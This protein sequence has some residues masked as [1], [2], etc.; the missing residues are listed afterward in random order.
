MTETPS[1]DNERLCYTLF[2]REGTAAELV[3]WFHVSGLEFEEHTGE[4]GQHYAAL[5]GRL[6][7]HLRTRNKPGDPFSKTVLG[8]YSYFH[9]G[10][11][12]LADRSEVKRN[13]LIRLSE[14]DMSIGI[15]IAPPSDDCEQRVFAL[16]ER[17]DALVF[18]GTSLL[19]PRKEVLLEGR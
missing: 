14:A 7:L 19:T 18:D 4:R 2:A 8:L 15:V 13:A 17:L 10:G 12:K 11:T 3:S 9:P 1:D 6:R 16:A 5:N